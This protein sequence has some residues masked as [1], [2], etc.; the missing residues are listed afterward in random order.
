MPALLKSTWLVSISSWGLVSMSSLTVTSVLYLIGS[1]TKASI[2]LVP[3]I[4]GASESLVT[5]KGTST[6]VSLPEESD[7]TAFAM[8]L[9]P[10]EISGT[11]A[12]LTV[13][14]LRS[15]MFFT[16]SSTGGTWSTENIVCGTASAVG[17]VVS[18]ILRLHGKFTPYILTLNLIIWGST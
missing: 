14:S 13:V 17:G 16:H 7:T 8:M 6:I 18:T 15:L 9:P 1:P 11:S 5:W 2:F 4:T 3:S 10:P 12:H